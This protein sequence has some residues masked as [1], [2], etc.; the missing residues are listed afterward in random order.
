MKWNCRQIEPLLKA[1][2]DGE[3]EP[4]R[5]AAVEQHVAACSACREAA[6]DFRA[7]SRRLR[8]LA[9][10]PVV[11]ASAFAV[12]ARV[13]EAAGEERLCV[14]SLQR[15]AL[16]AAA[17]LAVALGATFWS[18]DAGAQDALTVGGAAAGLDSVLEVAFSDLSWRD[19]L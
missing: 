10:A 19:E 1:W 5:D 18:A 2:L 15:I 16:S 11:P 3:L 7:I 14:R 9:E 17:L 6:G 8:A 13:R 4:P 12:L